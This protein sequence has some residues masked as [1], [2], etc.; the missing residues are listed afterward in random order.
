MAVCKCTPSIR[1]PWCRNCRTTDG[2]M[3]FLAPELQPHGVEI[4]MT[5]GI[6]IKQMVVPL[7]M[8]Y[9]PQ[10]SHKYDHTSMLAAGS[11]KVWA[12]DVYM[13]TYKAPCGILIKKGVKH[14]FLTLEDKTMIYCIHNLKDS[15]VVEVLEE[16][17]LTED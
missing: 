12:D 10:H 17:H 15:D 14:K 1:T 11:V 8:T 4:Y 5:D 13:G 6:F 2:E 7:R 3:K 9:V 16:H